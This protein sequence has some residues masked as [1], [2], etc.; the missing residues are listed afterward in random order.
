MPSS[1]TVFKTVS[2]Y[3]STIFTNGIS[4]S[5]FNNLETQNNQ[6][7]LF[8]AATVSLSQ[9]NLEKLSQ[10]SKQNAL[11]TLSSAQ[12]Y[13][14][15]AQN[16]VSEIQ[17]LVDKAHSIAKT[18]EGQLDP[19][20][21]TALSDE[22]ESLISEITRI[23]QETE[24]NGETIINSGD[25]SFSINLGNVDLT[26]EDTF[27]VSVLNIDATTQKLGLSGLTSGS[28]NTDSTNTVESLESAQSRLL[29]IQQ[30]LSNSETQVSSI[31][32]SMGIKTKL[33]LDSNQKEPPEALA[34]SIASSLGGSLQNTKQTLLDPE[35]VISL[36]ST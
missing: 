19:T 14:D 22:G 5:T 28:F 6:S 4:T 16:A 2:P 24:F 23:A 9:N 21:R 29:S 12:S 20:L 27:S 1:I 34:D 15:I 8:D 32:E 10:R 3:L 25:E 26:S 7:N 13:I 18:L 31:A 36:L 30:N 35:N 33:S 11:R 17:N